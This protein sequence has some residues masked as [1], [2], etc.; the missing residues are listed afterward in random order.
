LYNAISFPEEAAMSRASRTDLVRAVFA[1]YTSADRKALEDALADDF[2]F[3]SPYDD[4][5]GKAAY[6]ERCWPSGLRIER[7]DLERIFVEGEEAFVTYKCVA[8]N[9]KTFRNTEFFTFAGD[10]IS[11]IDVYFGTTYRDGEFLKLPSP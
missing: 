9:G 6:F 8:K 5:I 2:V 7:R 1:A 10:R 4:E 3:T 11:R